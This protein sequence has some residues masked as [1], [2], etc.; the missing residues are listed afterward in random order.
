MFTHT[1]AQNLYSRFASAPGKWL[2]ENTPLISRSAMMIYRKC[3]KGDAQ[4]F[5]DLMRLVLVDAM[6]G[7]EG[8]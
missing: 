6:L 4:V 3:G 2:L 8:F 7:R 5:I 1:L